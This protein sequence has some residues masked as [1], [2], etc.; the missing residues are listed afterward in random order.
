MQALKI[1]RSSC[2]YERDKNEIFIINLFSQKWL[3]NPMVLQGSYGFGHFCLNF[4]R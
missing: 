1:D 3:R 2:V 4:V